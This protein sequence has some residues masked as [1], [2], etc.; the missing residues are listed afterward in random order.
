MRVR[1][2]KCRQL[3]LKSPYRTLSQQVR[4]EER[5]DGRGEKREGRDGINY[6]S[7]GKKG[8]KGRERKE[9][10][11]GRERRGEKRRGGWRQNLFFFSSTE[12]Y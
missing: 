6:Q 3:L 1:A 2:K 11:V 10:L 9:S 7:G 8:E 5:W 4:R 12:S